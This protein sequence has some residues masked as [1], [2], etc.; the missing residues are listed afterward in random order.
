MICSCEVLDF[1]KL[2]EQYALGNSEDLSTVKNLYLKNIH[3]NEAEAE[4]F[5]NALPKVRKQLKEDLQ[6]FMKSDPAIDSEEEV[7]LAYPGFKAIRYHRIAHILY[8]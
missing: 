4:Q 3:N 8:G 5:V 7:I 6:F 1:Y 2:A